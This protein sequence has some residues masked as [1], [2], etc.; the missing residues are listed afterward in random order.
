[1]DFGEVIVVVTNNPKIWVVLV[2]APDFKENDGIMYHP[3]P[4]HLPV[5]LKYQEMTYC[6]LPFKNLLQISRSDFRGNQE[7]QSPLITH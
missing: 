3:E 6:S 5:F 4:H 2:S 7:K 1:M